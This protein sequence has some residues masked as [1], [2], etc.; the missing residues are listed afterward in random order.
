ML[1]RPLVLVV[2]VAGNDAARLV[3]VVDRALAVLGSIAHV[4]GG[5]VE[6]V[7]V[8]SLEDVNLSIEGP[9]GVVNGPARQRVRGRFVK[10]NHEQPTKRARHRTCS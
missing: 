2:A 10:G 6:G 7:V 8:P 5:L 4:E 9:V 3:D 1:R